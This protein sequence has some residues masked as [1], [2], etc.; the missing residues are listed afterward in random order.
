MTRPYATDEQYERGFMAV[1]CRC[2]PR[3]HKVGTCSDRAARTRGACPGCGQPLG[4]NHLSTLLNQVGIPIAAARDAAI[5]QQLLELPAPIVADALGYHDQTTSRLRN[6]TAV[7]RNHTPLAIT[8]CH[9]RLE[10]W[11]NS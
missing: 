11:A 3:R 8:H 6:E 4:P 1:C 2:G 9:D 7:T 5:R 10:S